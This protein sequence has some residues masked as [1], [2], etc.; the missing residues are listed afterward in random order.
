MHSF[1]RFLYESFLTVFVR[2]VITYYSS[3]S[4][5]Y[6]MF[7]FLRLM[8]FGF[9]NRFVYKQMCLKFFICRWVLCVCISLTVSLLVNQTVCLSFCL[10]V[11][12]L[13]CLLV[14]PPVCLP[15]YLSA[16]HSLSLPFHHLS[17]WMFVGLSVR[18]SFHLSLNIYLWVCMSD[19]LFVFFSCVF[20]SL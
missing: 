6:Y 15:D 3:K 7:T 19:W 11:C 20:V 13:I 16:C 4:G 10:S 9:S 5:V 17:N 18:Q 8:N 14:F 12:L 1:T 2:A